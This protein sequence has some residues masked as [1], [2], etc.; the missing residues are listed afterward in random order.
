MGKQKDR[1]IPT[2]KILPLSQPLFPVEEDNKED[3]NDPQQESIQP[4]NENND[5]LGST[6]TSITDMLQM[7]HVRGEKHKCKHCSKEFPT[8]RGVNIHMRACIKK[9]KKQQ[10]RQPT[11]MTD[12]QEEVTQTEPATPNVPSECTWDNLESIMSA[13]ESIYEEIVFWWKNLFKLPSGAAGKRYI[14]ELTRLIKIWNEDAPLSICVLKLCMIMPAVLLQKPSRK[15]TAK[16]HGQYLR[17]RMDLWEEG[18]FGEL[19]KEGRAIQEK[20]KQPMKRIENYEELAKK[21]AKLMMEGKVHAALRLLDKRAADGVINMTEEV[22][23]ELQKLHP[24]GKEAKDEIL[25]TGEVP[26]FDPVIFSNIDESSI[27]SAA[28][29]TRGAAGPSGMD[30]DQWRR[31]LISKNYGAVGKDLREAIAKMT[32]KLCTL[33]IQPSQ[34]GKTSIEAYTSCRLVSLEKQPSGIRPIGIGEVLR[35]II[36]KAIVTEIKSDLAESAGSLQLCA[37]QKAGCEAA[38]HAM[39]DIFAESETD[40]VLLVDASN[41]F[42]CL[43]RK[44]LLHNIRYLCP[45]IS[46]YIRNC[47]GS[48]ARLFLTGGNEIKSAEGTTQGD[49]TAMPAYGIGILPL[50]NLI[51]PDIEPEKMKHVA[52]ADDLGGGSKLEKLRNW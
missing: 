38:A 45:A 39:R 52:Y 6:P 10:Q 37:G 18:K 35:R 5:E 19:L 22:F 2:E 14:K 47:Y 44:A 13:A 8:V 50:L 16:Q 34:E 9:L 24:D 40:G 4:D 3:R 25:L 29:R 11:V 51:K 28:I 1:I 15:S 36:G 48:P 43:N 23:R 12:A 7:Q 46:T 27:A 30:A 33:E 21:F 20:L 41:A 42:N 17:R 31:I 49:P 32:Q 26:F